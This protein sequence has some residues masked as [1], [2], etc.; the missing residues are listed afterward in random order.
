MSPWFKNEGF[1]ERVKSD[2]DDKLDDCDADASKV[3][4]LLLCGLI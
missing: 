4:E 2:D 3:S 1:N